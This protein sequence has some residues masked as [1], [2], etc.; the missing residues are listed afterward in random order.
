MRKLLIIFIILFFV[1]NPA[2]NTTEQ[3]ETSNEKE[4]KVLIEQ[5]VESFKKND[6]KKSTQ[7]LFRAKD[8]AEE[9]NNYGLTAKIYGSL[10][11]QYMQLNLDDSAKKYLDKAIQQI[12][13]MPEG[14]DKKL[15]KGLSYLDLGNITFDEKKFVDAN[16]YYKKSLKEFQSAK[17]EKN[18]P[19]YHYRRSLYNIGN[20]FIYINKTDSAEQFLNKALVIKDDENKELNFFI[21]NALSQIYT[22]KGQY[23]RSIDSLMNIINNKNLNNVRLESDIYYALSQN[24]KK[25]GNYDQSIFY[26]EKYVKLDNANKEKEFKAINSAMNEE[27][28]DYKDEISNADSNTK[29]IAVI[30]ILFITGFLFFIIYLLYK[31]KKERSAFELVIN[32]LKNDQ[33]TIITDVVEENQELKSERIT[34]PE[35][36]EKE[37]LIK[38]SK[39]EE[40]G[41][42]TN[43]KLNISNL[44]VSLKTNTSYLSD[45]INHHK[46]KNF[47]SYINELRIAYICEKI[48]KN[49]EYLNYKISYLAEESGFTSHSSFATVFK[50]I[51]GISPSAFLREASKN[52]NQKNH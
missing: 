41:K 40:S 11:H 36:A 14:D 4:S 2:Q 50:N 16:L 21:T 20:S 15:F 5:A 45:V 24:Y 31:R 3:V 7:L 37:L 34:V 33:T 19:V 39:F 18:I 25:I 52:F 49:K 13:K 29:T 17:L 35:L 1:Q 10:A 32:N 26:N 9:S 6:F 47:N 51:T 44:A 22:Q 27:Q 12:N 38:L 28:K 42:F 23:Q 30:S 43:P 8:L 46:G 48:Y